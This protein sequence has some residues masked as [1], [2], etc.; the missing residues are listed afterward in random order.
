MGAS[1][2]HGAPEERNTKSTKGKI[3]KRITN[4]IYK[5]RIDLFIGLYVQDHFNSTFYLTFYLYI[6]YKTK[7][8]LS[9]LQL[10]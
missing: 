10:K 7:S 8:T 3:I 2:T 6:I 4:S 9:S 5:K 1:D